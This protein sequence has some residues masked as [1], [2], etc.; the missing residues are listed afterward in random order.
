MVQLVQLTVEGDLDRRRRSL[1]GTRGGHDGR[2][3]AG[4][5]TAVSESIA[6]ASLAGNDSS[7]ASSAQEDTV[8][9]AG[10][11]SAVSA[12]CSSE[13]NPAFAR[14]SGTRCCGRLG[15]ARDGTT[16]ARSSST[17]SEYRAT[18][19]GSCQSPC[20]LA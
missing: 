17:N 10:A 2:P 11:A 12:A 13:R 1:R 20:S 14:S 18:S 16:D 6:G 15:P 8:S 3:V 19:A 5:P 4:T 7:D 9:A